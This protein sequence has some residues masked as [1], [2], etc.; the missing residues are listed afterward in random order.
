MLKFKTF[1][2]DELYDLV[3]AEYCALQLEK[4]GYESGWY[5]F[6][7]EEDY[8]KKIQSLGKYE[9]KFQEDLRTAAK[10]ISESFEEL[11]NLQGEDFDT[12]EE[13]LDE[14]KMIQEEIMAEIGYCLDPYLIQ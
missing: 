14:R 7:S 4:S 11:A 5:D 1:T 6:V 13:F 2:I 12:E 3:S 9:E 8:E 10:S